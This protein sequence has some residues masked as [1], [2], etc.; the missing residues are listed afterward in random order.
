VHLDS[1]DQIV[2]VLD[3]AREL[4]ADPRARTAGR[5]AMIATLLFAGLRAGEAGYAVVRD[6]DLARA[7]LDVGR[8]KTDAGIRSIDLLPVLRDALAEH[9]ASHRG[10]LD[11]PLFPTA[12]GRHRDKDNIGHR[13]LAPV[14]RRADELLAERDQHPLPAGVTAHKLRHTFTSILVACGCD[15]AYVMQQRGHADPGAAR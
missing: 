15:P 1:V 8:S 9:K 6:L 4:D 11:D 12:T 3:A 7:R 10:G 2:A 13:V 14:V 5:H